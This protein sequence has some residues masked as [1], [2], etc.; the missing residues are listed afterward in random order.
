MQYQ[1]N[2]RLLNE[3]CSIWCATNLTHN[4]SNQ[5][6][7]YLKGCR[8]SATSHRAHHQPLEYHDSM[9]PRDLSRPSMVTPLRREDWP[10]HTTNNSS[11]DFIFSTKTEPRLHSRELD[12]SVTYLSII[13]LTESDSITNLPFSIGTADCNK[14]NPIHQDS[15]FVDCHLKSG[16]P[17]TFPTTNFP[18][19]NFPKQIFRHQSCQQT[20][21]PKPHFPTTNFPKG[22][23][24][25]NQDYFSIQWT[26]RSKAVWL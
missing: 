12:F 2:A 1:F 14:R 24:S 11:L 23:F 8:L 4:Y 25:D 10:P 21:F 7:S 20:N 22:I 26:N 15:I 13:S 16:N 17:K 18:T 6:Y 5:A 9:V 19:P 3:S